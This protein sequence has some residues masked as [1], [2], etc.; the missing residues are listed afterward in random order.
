MKKLLV[1][2]RPLYGKTVYYPV[3]KE[4]VDICK[5]LALKTVTLEVARI[6]QILGYEIEI[7]KLENPFEEE[8]L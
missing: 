8:D 3:S 4:L 7:E 6:C 2:P 1:K 5:I